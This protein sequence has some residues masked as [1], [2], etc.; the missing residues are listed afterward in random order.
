MSYQ[1]KRLLIMNILDILKRYTDEDHRLSQKEI[2]D[3]LKNEYDMTVDR[4]SVK[5]N[6]MNLIDSGYNIEYSETIRMMPNSKT[7]Q[8]EENIILSDFYLVRDFNDGELRLL[9]D[10]LLFSKHITYSQCKELIEK[11]EGLSSIYFRKKVKHIANLSQ[12]RT[13]NKQLFYTID[14][15]DEAIRK[16]KK[17]SFSY[18]EYG[19]DKKLHKRKC[20]DGNIRKYIISPYQLVIK[21][22][23]YYLIC[24]Y[25]KYNDISNYRI[26]RIADIKLLDVPAKPFEKL[27]GANKQRLDLEKYMDEH[28]YMY[29]SETI[30]VKFRIVKS[31]ISDIIDMFGMDV[32]FSD[33]TVSYVTVTARVNEMAMYQFA[34]EF[35]PDV[36][37]LSP[38][39]LADKVKA[40]AEKAVKV[41]DNLKG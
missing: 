22:G 38:Q 9:I 26:D 2:V 40:N 10:S 11:L 32:R 1:P 19:T 15:L 18:C 7:G 36:V 33:E 35:A 24:N 17:V 27:D 6:L 28:I 31:M 30:T 13:N 23:K 14:I 41:Y 25:D 39:S 29:S 4:K 20:K 8:L 34:K 3:I 37:V 12:D 21:E 5:R 16:G